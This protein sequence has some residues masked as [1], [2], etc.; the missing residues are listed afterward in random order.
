[1]MCCITWGIDGALVVPVIATAIVG[2]SAVAGSAY[3]VVAAW[4]E[5]RLRE[6]SV[7]EIPGVPDIAVVAPCYAA[8]GAFV[9]A[10]WACFSPV[11]LPVSI[12][13]CVRSKTTTQKVR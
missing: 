12:M 3:G 4:R 10:I 7:L 6:K 8:M 13:Y 1:M 9:G 11:L 5:T 2:S